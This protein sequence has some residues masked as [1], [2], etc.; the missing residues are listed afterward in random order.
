MYISKYFIIFLQYTNIFI[1][2]QNT[3]SNRKKKEKVKDFEVV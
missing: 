1:Y 3:N 2:T